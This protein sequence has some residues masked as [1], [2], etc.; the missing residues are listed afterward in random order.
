MA[1]FRRLSRLGWLAVGSL[2]VGSA[3]PLLT[4]GAEQTSV[5]DLVIHHGTVYDGTGQPGFHGEVAIDGDRITYVGPDRGMHGR[6]EVDAK[7]QAIA[8]GFINML[9]HQ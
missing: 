5:H 9:A 6:T 2:V 4:F 3:V 8:P 7:G 1:R